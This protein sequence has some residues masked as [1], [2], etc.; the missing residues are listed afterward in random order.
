M[1]YRFFFNKMCY[2]LPFC[3]K[4]VTAL[5]RKLKITTLGLSMTLNRFEAISATSDVRERDANGL[6]L[7]EK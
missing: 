4:R 5:F 6:N 2:Y 1:N 3:C 7:S